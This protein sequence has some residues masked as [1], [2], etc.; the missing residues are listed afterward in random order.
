MISCES[1]VFW[2]TGQPQRKIKDAN[3]FMKVGG[4][5]NNV[6]ESL[7][8]KATEMSEDLRVKPS[9]IFYLQIPTNSTTYENLVAGFSTN[10]F[11]KYMQPS[12]WIMK[13]QSWKWKFQKNLWVFHH[14]PPRDCVLF[15]FPSKMLGRV[16]FSPP[17]S[18]KLRGDHMALLRLGDVSWSKKV[19]FFWGMGNSSHLEGRNPYNGYI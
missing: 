3:C 6:D 10:P 16:I 14:H 2:R 1:C 19:A 17:A 4:G 18:S 11:K 15:F 8:T 12:N 7:K 5:K 13:P 9:S